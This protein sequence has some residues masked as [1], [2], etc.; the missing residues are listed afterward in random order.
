MPSIKDPSE[1][2]AIARKL[3]QTPAFMQATRADLAR[4]IASAELKTAA[5]GQIICEPTSPA[6]PN[7]APA[8]TFFF[9]I[10]GEFTLDGASML[11]GSLEGI[12]GIEDVLWSRP[13]SIKLQCLQDGKYLE[14]RASAFSDLRTTSTPFRQAL[15][16]HLKSAVDVGKY[17]SP[18][19][20]CGLGNAVQFLT[21]VSELPLSFMMQLLGRSIAASFPDCVVIARLTKPGETPSET[22]IPG[23]GPGRLV[24]ATLASNDILDLRKRFDYVFLDGVL[25]TN[26]EIIVNLIFGY[27]DE[28]VP[29]TPLHAP[30]VLRTVL[31]GKPPLPCSKTLRFVNANPARNTTSASCRVVLD[32]S[33]LRALAQSWNPNLP[34]MVLDPGLDKEIGIWAR[35]LTRR[36]TGIALAGGGVWSMQSVYILREL[37]KR[38]VPVDIM[39]GASAG[40]MIGGYYTALGLPGLERMVE[41]GDRGVLDAVVLLWAL[42]GEFAQIFFEH[43]Y[44]KQSCLEELPFQFHP[45]STNLTTGLGVAFTRGPVATAVRAAASAPPICQPT[46]NNKQRFADGAFSNNVAAQVLP[47]FGADLTYA[48]NTYPSSR[49]PSPWWVPQWVSNLLSLGPLNRML[50]FTVALNILANATGVVE[51]RLADVAFNATSPVNAPY[52]ITTDFCLSSKVL[53]AAANNLALAE[54][55]DQFEREWNHLKNRG[56]KGLPLTP[57]TLP[58]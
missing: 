55:I 27:E 11:H 57:S 32:L 35:A 21:E 2:D 53:E 18:V 45:N 40:A 5:P 48:A 34:T 50:D 24:I 17:I 15:H 1:F 8:S 14:F 52:L 33:A 6:D 4:L 23:P 44:G 37:A 41:Q 12:V 20:G 9:L 26:V 36:R 7:E 30:W 3:G 38:N 31:V 47:Y 58:A 43:E 16:P 22:E 54:S 49:R 10:D 19:C 25:A 42:S 56:A 51:S 29:P 46:F 28:Y 13:R 39:T